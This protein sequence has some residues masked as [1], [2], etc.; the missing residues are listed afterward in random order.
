MKTE[1]TELLNNVFCDVIEQVTF[2]FG[3][4]VGKEKLPE[5]T[6]E[7]I[8]TKMSFSGEFGGSLTLLVP[9]GICIE[10]AAN[11]LGL[12]PEDELVETSSGDALKELLNVICGNILTTI[13]G[14]KPIFDLSIPVN[15]NLDE[16]GWINFLDSEN[17]VGFMVDDYPVL[18]EF[19]ISDN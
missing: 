6:S 17:S 1:H 2:M 9:T 10:I 15:E 19:M 5:P 18:L 13:A 3:E 7:Y 8:R 14:D 16:K 4:S 12:D 11:I